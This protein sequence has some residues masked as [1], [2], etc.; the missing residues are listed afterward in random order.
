MLS[1]RDEAVEAYD[2]LEAA[3]R[4]CAALRLDA[5]T[6]P[7]WFAVLARVETVRR[8]LPSL[9]HELINRLVEQGVPAEIGGPVAQVLADRLRISP[10]AARR[11]INEAADLGV[12]TALTG[13]PL[14]P[15]LAGTAAGQR[16]GVVGG[17]QVRVIRGFFHRLPEAVDVGTRYAAEAQLAGLAARLRPDELRVV[18][19]RITAWVNPDGSFTDAE[20]ARK[21]GVTLGRQGGDGMSPINGLLD[22]EARSYLEA[23]F[24]AYAAP[25]KANPDDQSPTVDGEPGDDQARRDTRSPAQRCHDAL[26]LMG[27]DAMGNRAR[28]RGLP[29]SVIVSTTLRE[30]QA[31][32]GKAVTGGGSWLPM[33]DVIRLASHAHHYLVIFDHH[34]HRALYLARDRRFASPA[35]R[36]VLHAS[37][38]GCSHPGCDKPGY[39]CEVH[40][41][42]EWADGGA[43]N[44]DSLTFA[45]KPHHR[46]LDHGWKTRKHRDGTTEWIPPPH[47][48]HGKPRTNGYHHPERYL[49]NDE[50]DEPK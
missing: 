46:L 45:C 35:Q 15:V 36:I 18:A 8:R 28:H 32:S 9:Q 11:R 40:H 43:T 23:F 47:L 50:H 1:D 21:R 33:S 30:L 3:V 38:R 48:D 26:K 16:A 25:G 5:L 7:E 12:R 49:T 44:V 31:G 34:T 10:T 6:T 14:E 39:L 13:E 42:D 27:R 24:A 37:D 17:E 29:V 4:R 19:E 2:E 41:V 22:P 20:R